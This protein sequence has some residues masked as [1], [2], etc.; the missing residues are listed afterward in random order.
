MQRMYHQW[1][2]I[3]VFQSKYLE[4]VQCCAY[5]SKTSPVAISLSYLLSV[6]PTT[7]SAHMTL[8]RVAWTLEKLTK[9][10]KIGLLIV[11]LKFY[12]MENEVN[13]NSHLE[14]RCPQLCWNSQVT[15]GKMEMS[16]DPEVWAYKKFPPD[17]LM[18]IKTKLVDCW[19]TGSL[20]TKTR[21]WLNQPIWKICAKHAGWK[22]QQ[23]LSCHHPLIGNPYNG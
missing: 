6:L 1:N 4:V 12:S 11:T 20:A 13:M 21:W 14:S 10:S 7:H 22:F 8:L 16:A 19:V 5:A 15:V 17:I 9:A 18:V 3:E 23:C 2:V